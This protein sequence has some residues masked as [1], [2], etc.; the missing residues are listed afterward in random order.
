MMLFFGGG[1][2]VRQK[3]KLQ[4]EGLIKTHTGARDLNI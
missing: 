3:H 2:A 1:G 4:V